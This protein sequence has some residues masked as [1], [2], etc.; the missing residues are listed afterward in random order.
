MRWLKRLLVPFQYLRFRWAKWKHRHTIGPWMRWNLTR[1]E[2]REILRTGWVDTASTPLPVGRNY[3]Q[4][5]ES[6]AL[7]RDPDGIS[8]QPIDVALR[9]QAEED[10]EEPKKPPGPLQGK[11]VDKKKAEK[12]EKAAALL[13][14]APLVCTETK[15]ADVRDTIGDFWVG[16]SPEQ[17][18]MAGLGGSLGT[19]GGVT[20]LLTPPDEERNQT[21]LGNT[22]GGVVGGGLLGTGMGAGLGYGMPWMR[23][24]MQIIAAKNQA[25][26]QAAAQRARLEGAWEGL[27]G[28]R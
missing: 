16:L 8:L 19:L 9:K 20:G 18:L 28:D 14:H 4:L 15:Q 10:D 21:R 17:K 22:L 11:Y 1:E 5:L 3:D 24:Q 27:F 12:A 2:K 25:R 26:N 23:R 13:A 7:R 6:L